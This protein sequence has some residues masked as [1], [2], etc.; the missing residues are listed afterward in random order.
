MKNT[1]DIL[2]KVMTLLSMDV[3][4][5]EMKLENGTTLVSDNFEVGTEVFIQSAEDGTNVPVPVGEYKME[6]GRTLIVEEEGIIAGI[7]AEVEGEEGVSIE[8]EAAEQEVIETEVPAEVAPAMEEVVTAVVEAIAPIIEEVKAEMAALREEMGKKKE[9][10]SAA[11][12]M[13]R[14]APVEKERAGLKLN[15]QQTNTT[16]SR[17]MNRLFG[18]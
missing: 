2:K 16:S 8:V 13:K 14:H 9:N 17:V 10:M 11:A 4:L 12:P 7:K 18:K 3:K 15:T 6:D 5:A 1:N